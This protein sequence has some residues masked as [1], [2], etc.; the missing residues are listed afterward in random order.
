M[1]R[2]AWRQWRAV[3][4]FVF[5]QFCGNLA[6]EAGREDVDV[7]QLPRLNLDLIGRL[8]PGPVEDNLR[9]VEDDRG[10]QHRRERCRLLGTQVQTQ[11]SR[12]RSGGT[13]ARPRVSPKTRPHERGAVLAHSKPKPVR[14]RFER[15]PKLEDLNGD[16]SKRLVLGK[17]VLNDEQLRIARARTVDEIPI[18]YIARLSTR[19]DQSLGIQV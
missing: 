10:V 12:T 2:R 5:A 17:L 7:E 15:Q 3:A 9:G 13:R 18:G 6:Q 14:R 8:V 16:V 1:G 4:R 11:L 19:A